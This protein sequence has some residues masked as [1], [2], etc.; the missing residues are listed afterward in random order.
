MKK[1]DVYKL[2][3]MLICIALPMITL[4]QGPVDPDDTTTVPIDGGLSLLITAGAAYV[5]KKY[6]AHKPNH[7]E[8]GGQNI[9]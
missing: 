3:I 2:I 9:K 6:R 4:A 1:R 7:T 8:D 5:V